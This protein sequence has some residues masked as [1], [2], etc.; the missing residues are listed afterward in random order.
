[1]NQAERWRI[2]AVSY[3]NTLPL[4]HGM[5]DSFD[6]ADLVFDL[7]SRLADQLAAGDLDVALIP[8]IEVF[9]NAGYT[10]LSNA[11]IA[12]SGPVWSVKLMSRVPLHSIRT[13]ALDEGSRTSGALVRLLLERQ[14]GIR[15]QIEPLSID[16]NWRDT[17]CDAVLIIGDR[18]MNPRPG[19]GFHS[20]TDLGQW[21]KEL[22]GLPF[23][24]AMWTAREGLA[25]ENLDR[26][27]SW[28]TAS[29]DAGVQAIHEIARD[30]SAEYGLSF[31][32]CVDYFE[33]HLHFSL[34]PG[35]REGLARF[36]DLA[37]RMNFAPQA[38]Q[39]QFHDC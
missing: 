27:D 28:L 34:G 26:I 5:S 14:Y 1:M 37:A 23:V 2:G 16:A 29:R 11:C 20:E 4:V 22:T 8:S 36:R 21:W 15:P 33:K 19:G 9:Q 30:R 32:Q 25:P 18:A 13:L 3:L 31:R 35:E 39:T 38:L 10:V 6:E 17:G 7:P 24:F 12:C